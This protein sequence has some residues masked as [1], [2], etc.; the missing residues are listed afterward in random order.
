MV[1]NL[2]GMG[3]STG[4]STFPSTLP[5]SSIITNL[6]LMASDLYAT[7]LSASK[8]SIKDSS[9]I[10]PSNISSTDS[11]PPVFTR[12]KKKYKPVLQKVRPLVTNLPDWFRI[13][14]NITGDPLEN[15]PKL[16]PR[17]PSFVPTPWYSLECKAII[18]KNY[19][20][21]FLW[22][23]ERNIMHDFIQSHE[24]GLVWHEN[25]Q[26][27]FRADFFPPIEFP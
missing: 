1:E 23:E 6:Y 19:P 9:S 2:L 12:M 5:L 27:N 8:A 17:P 22:P 11:I 3:K 7:F 18:D 14:Q 4:K 15:M 21:D 26:G 10:S 16:N 24:T 20:G 13:V 25:K